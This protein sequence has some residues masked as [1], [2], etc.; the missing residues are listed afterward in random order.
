[1]CL[2]NRNLAH[3]ESGS[4]K[5]SEQMDMVSRGYVGYERLI[6]YHSQRFGYMQGTFESV[7]VQ[8]SGADC[9]AS[10]VVATAQMFVHDFLFLLE[11]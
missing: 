6:R 8:L 5:D 1:M 11:S 2:R 7:Y 4:H 9:P 3:S 10:R